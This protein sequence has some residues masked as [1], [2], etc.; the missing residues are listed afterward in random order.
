MALISTACEILCNMEALIPAGFFFFFLNDSRYC[1]YE[2][3]GLNEAVYH[4]GFTPCL[5]KEL[6]T[7]M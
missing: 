5:S 3:Q 2:V 4:T 7:D 6:P 1:L